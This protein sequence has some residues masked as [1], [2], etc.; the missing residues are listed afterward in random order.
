MNPHS[1]SRA[2]YQ[3]MVVDFLDVSS[4]CH[5]LIGLHLLHLLELLPDLVVDIL[6]LALQAPV[7]GLLELPL[8]PLLLLGV[9]D[10]VDQHL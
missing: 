1:R 5:K 7:L 4:K 9:D 8:L 6:P 2:N 10:K 3:P